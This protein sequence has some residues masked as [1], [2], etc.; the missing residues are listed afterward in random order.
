MRITIWDHP[1]AR[2]LFSGLASSPYA[3]SVTVTEM[4]STETL[5]AL[6]SGKTDIA[7]IST[8][9][10]LRNH[11]IVDVLPAVAL[12]AWK[13]PFATLHLESGLTAAPD[14][15]AVDA[16]FEQESAVARIV[17]KEHYRMTPKFVTADAEAPGPNRV[18]ASSSAEVA[19]DTIL[20]LGQEWFELSGYPML[21]GVFATL[22]GNVE[23]ATV[24]T[25]R[26]IV[27]ISEAQRELFLR[28][29][30][31]TPEMHDFFQ[32]QIRVR[33]DDL[34]IAGLTEFRQFLFF[35]GLLDDMTDLPVAFLPD[36]DDEEE[37]D[38]YDDGDDQPLM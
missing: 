10:A 12:S 19:G 9:E 5:G 24:D 6:I 25:M 32:N 23:E 3:S 36:P 2:F 16:A 22:K 34:A 21:W 38:G 29:H 26:G 27:G 15:V 14:E 31:Q 33:F 8:L 20:D 18:A 1:A 35:Y 17:L 4:A 13:Y 37:V 7:L 11:D 30:E 28:T